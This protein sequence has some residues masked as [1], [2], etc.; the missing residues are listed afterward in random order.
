MLGCTYATS[1]CKAQNHF[2]CWQK[3]C[4]VHMGHVREGLWARARLTGLARAGGGLLGRRHGVHLQEGAHRA[5]EPLMPQEISLHVALRRAHG[6]LQCTQTSNKRE[7]H[8]IRA[9]KS[10]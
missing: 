9:L 2:H 3:A 5:Q 10:R 7:H 8:F 6:K 1:C 4:C